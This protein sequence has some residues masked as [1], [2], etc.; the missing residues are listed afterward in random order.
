MKVRQLFVV[1]SIVTLVAIGVI[2]YFWPGIL[3][4]LIIILPLIALGFADISQT[5]H[6]IRRNFP[7]IG[8]G[9]YLLESIRPEIMQYFVETDT[10]GKPIDRLMRSM[11]YRRAKNVIDTVPF[12]TQLDVY[13]PGYEWLNHSMYAGKI[14]HA[15]D[16]RVKVGGSECKQ[17]YLASLLN[18][19]AMSF[20]SLSENAVLAMNKG[21]K[22]GNFAHN[23]GEGGISPYHLQPGGDLIWQIGTGYFGCRAADGGFDPDKYVER[24]TLPNVKMIELKI[25]QGAKPGH[26][27]ILP[28]NKNTPEI[29]KIRAVEPYTTVDSP[30]SHSAFSDA[31]G[32]LHFIKQLRELS[33]GKPVGFK[34]CIGIKREF[35]EI[36]EAMIKTGIKPDYIAIDGGEGGTGAAPVEFSNSLGMPLLDGLAFAV[37]TLRGYGLKKDIRVVAS[38]KI[39]SSFHIARAMAIGAD[40]VYSARAMMMAVGCIQALQCN[41]NTC[42]VGV[43]TQDRELMKGLDVEDKATRMYNFHKKTMHILSELISATGVKSHRDFNRSHVNLRIDNTRIMSYDQLYPIVEEGAYVG[44]SVEDVLQEIRVRTLSKVN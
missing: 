33:G 23:T 2:S 22:L 1:G 13:E 43:A 17:P 40:L 16:P 29:A 41:T 26:G 19:S 34:L 14:K 28:A 31:E 44:M 18:I 10:E 36:C 5:K 37:D 8:H 12:G 35:I 42:P 20:G 38:G 21:A 32:M 7:I 3:W 25:S 27:G 4:S 15:D 39:I 30:P 11:V 9:R 6:A 24:A